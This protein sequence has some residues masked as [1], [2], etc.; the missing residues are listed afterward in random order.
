MS[1]QERR[2][3]VVLVDDHPSV[4]TAFRRMLEPCCDVLASVATGGEAIDAV[5]RLRPDI[6]VLDLMLPDTDGLAV[7]RAVK[8]AVPETD[9]ILVTAFDDR[10]IEAA[11][12]GCGASAFVAKHSA[13]TLLEREIQR[14]FAERT[15]ES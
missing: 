15:F 9:V 12:L 3:R 2:P 14:L 13:A 8:Q 6:L 11:A 5:I 10:A 1:Q 7:C 4:L